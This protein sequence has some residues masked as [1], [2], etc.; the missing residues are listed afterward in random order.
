MIPIALNRNRQLEIAHVVRQL[1]KLAQHWERLLYSTGGAI[2]MQKS[3]WYLMTWIWT[4]C[5]PRLATIHTTPA[6]LELTT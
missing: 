4:N 2:N 3:H 5:I 1:T 6:G